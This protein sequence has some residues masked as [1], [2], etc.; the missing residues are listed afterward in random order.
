MS[1]LASPYTSSRA[2]GAA[3]SSL[4]A[5][6]VAGEQ[7]AVVTFA[8]Q[9]VDVL[10]EL[11]ALVAQRPELLAGAQLASDVLGEVAASPRGLVSGAY[12]HGTDVAAWVLDPDGAPP[13]PYLRGA[14]IAYP[15]SLLA[16]ALLWR[17]V[18]A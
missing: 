13:L 10:D 7:R 4:A 2:A 3:A 14:A 9:G 6:L 5:R 18:H 11:A 12:R 16:Q 8:G 17:V 1:L 15:L